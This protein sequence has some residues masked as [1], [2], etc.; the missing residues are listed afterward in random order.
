MVVG[1]FLPVYR[2]GIEDGKVTGMD[3]PYGMVVQEGNQCGDFLEDILRDIT[4]SGAR[5]G[6]VS[7]FIKFLCQREG[8]FCRITVS[9]VG[10]LLQGGQVVQ[11]RRF[12]LR[13]LADYRFYCDV[14]GGFDLL[15][16][17]G[18]FFLVEAAF[19]IRKTEVFIVVLYG[20]A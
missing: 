7:S 14:R 12:L 1:H 2:P 19:G 4:T 8:L 20:K 3:T 11:K 6:N 15:I 10:F 13:L 9:A 18:G 16:Q 17:G 5:I